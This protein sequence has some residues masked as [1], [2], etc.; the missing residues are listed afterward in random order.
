VDHE[1]VDGD[2]I[3]VHE[4]IGRGQLAERALQAL[5]VGAIRS[6]TEAGPNMIKRT[7]RISRK[8]PT[9]RDDPEA[10]R[11]A[12]LDDY[13][14]EVYQ[15]QKQDFATRQAWLGGIRAAGDPSYYGAQVAQA[16]G[17]FDAEYVKQAARQRPKPSVDVAAAPSEF[18]VNTVT[19]DFHADGEKL[20]GL[21]EDGRKLLLLLL[22]R[23]N[24]R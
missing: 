11:E 13:R 4:P 8:P 21:T 14:E 24:E 6:F 10:Q 17:R 23:P 7:G 1:F 19:R 2:V 5:E 12:R 9:R 20:R 3:C 22:R 16:I 18:V 15:A